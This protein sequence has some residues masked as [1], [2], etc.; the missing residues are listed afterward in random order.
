[1][2]AS[3]LRAAPAMNPGTGKARLFAFLTPDH[4][5]RPDIERFEAELGAHCPPELLRGGGAPTVHA[6]LKAGPVPG[7]GWRV[8][9]LYWSL[10]RRSPRG[11]TAGTLCYGAKSGHCDWL[12]YPADPRLPG[13]ADYLAGAAQVEVLRYIPLRRAT[14]RVREPPGRSVVA[15]FKRASRFRDAWALLQDVERRVMQAQPGFRVPRALGVEE[16]RCLYFQEALPGRNLAEL[17]DGESAPA[18]LARLGEVHRRLHALPAEGLPRRPCGH[19]AGAA[20]ANAAW[21]GLMLPAL[22][23][24]VTGIAALLRET[25]PE[26]TA[27]AFCHGDPDCGQVLVEGDAWSLL[28]FDACH[29]GD[30][31]R[32][33]AMLA[34]S[35]DYHVPRLRALAEAPGHEARAVERAAQ[36][37]IEA[38]FGAAPRDAARL[39]WHRGCAELHY[40]ALTLKKDRYHP[41][42]F[43]RRWERLRAHAA[44][45]PAARE[46]IPG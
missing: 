45:L 11:F 25:A 30:P 31:Y 33:V 9:E 20:Q 19:D 27:P 10:Q 2:G 44:A 14:L 40:L 43:A 39:A 12:D 6:D 16:A 34:A 36:A 7:G 1:M 22:G 29:G 32:D 35:L 37:Y 8:A 26:E 41:R 5:L 46:R 28:D 24:P 23:D 21:I 15:K 4:P 17:L 38:Y 3:P 13:L 18:L 42:A